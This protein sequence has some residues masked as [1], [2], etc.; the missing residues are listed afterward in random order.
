[1]FSITTISFNKH[2]PFTLSEEDG[3]IKFEIWT[4]DVPVICNGFIVTV[5]INSDFIIPYEFTGEAHLRSL[6]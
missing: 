4:G 5:N 3:K 1:M 6:L 2:F